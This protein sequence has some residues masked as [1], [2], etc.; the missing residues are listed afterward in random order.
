MELET[1]ARAP[2]DIASLVF[3]RIGF[4]AL[5]AW[6]AWDYLTSGRVRYYYVEPQFHFTY[7]GWEWVRP[8]PGAGM[9]VHF[10][11]LAILAVGIAAGCCYRAACVMFALGF[12]YVFL[13]DATNYQ[14]HYYLIILVSG[15]LA[16][17]PAHRAVS[18]DA[19]WRPALYSDS[20]PAWSLWLVR[21]HVALPYVFGG[22]AKLDA[23]WL[24]GVPMRQLL[25]PHFGLPVLGDW[26]VAPPTALAFA[27][28]GLVFD[29]LIV[30]LL[31]WKWTR[32]PAYALCVALA[33]HTR[34]CCPVHPPSGYRP[35]A[36]SHVRHGTHCV[37]C[38]AVHAAVRYVPVGHALHGSQRNAVSVGWKPVAA[39]LRV[40]PVSHT[41]S[42]PVAS[43]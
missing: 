32:W 23:D 26:L 14:N 37:C 12:T 30:P 43:S 15:V 21:F 4:G 11:A 39:L 1:R 13:L 38:V 16:I 18:V 6:W 42:Q 31:L 3:F 2:V 34:S 25:A 22:I 20:A 27:W 36:A 40:N 28:G 35:D 5:A 29:L 7:A 10:L 33:T 17:V 41:H 19:A 9:Y 24:S 8:W